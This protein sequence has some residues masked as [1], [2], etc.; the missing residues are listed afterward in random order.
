MCKINREDFEMGLKDI[1]LFLLHA[2]NKKYDL[3]LVFGKIGRLKIFPD[4]VK[5]K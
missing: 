2:I 4:Y 5:M 3:A 1:H